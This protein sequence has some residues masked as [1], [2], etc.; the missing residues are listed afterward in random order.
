MITVDQLVKVAPPNL[1]PV[2]TQSLVDTINNVT[3]DPILLEDIR[4][5]Y[6]SYIGV[7]K[8]GKFKVEDYLHAVKYVSHKLMGDTNLDAYLKTFPQRHAA[9]L[10]K[11]T[12]AK[13]INS[14]VAAY[15]K[16]KLVN[17][18]LEQ[19][20]VPSW[21]MNQDAYQKAITVQ[22]ELMTTAVSEKVRCEA[23]NSLLTHLTKPKE[24][25]PLINLDMRESSGMNELREAMAKM[26]QQQVSLVNAGMTVKELAGQ[27]IIDAEIK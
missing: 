4:N 20:I 12:S 18:I 7:M 16:G 22:Y 19:S 24:V 17:L 26:A 11:G 8:D 5:N 25:G 6:I 13:D 21:I 2:I 9:L 27:V 3:T 1:K 14:Y 15:A 10:A 23:A